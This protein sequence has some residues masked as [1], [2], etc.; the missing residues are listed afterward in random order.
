MTQSVQDLRARHVKNLSQ[1]TNVTVERSNHRNEPE[2]ILPKT[3]SIGP[4]DFLPAH[5][6]TELQRSLL[7]PVGSLK[8]KKGNATSQPYRFKS[9]QEED[10]LRYITANINCLRRVCGNP[11]T[12]NQQNMKLRLPRSPLLSPKE[13]AE[14]KQQI[15]EFYIHFLQRT[16]QKRQQVYFFAQRLAQERN[17]NGFRDPISMAEKDRDMLRTLPLL[18]QNQN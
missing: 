2:V 3:Q 11:L 13:L 8:A 14:D 18:P 7:D 9:K 15:K 4:K 10:E 5:L 16:K 1:D 12:L 6:R 17:L